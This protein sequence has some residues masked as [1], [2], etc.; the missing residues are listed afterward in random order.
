MLASTLSGKPSP[1]YSRMARTRS[2][3]S[4]RRL[5]PTFILMARKPLARLLS[6]WRRSL[7]SGRSRT[8]PAG[9]DG[10]AGADAASL[11]E[12][13]VGVA[14]ELVERQLQIDAARVARHLGVEAAEVV[15]QGETRA[16]RL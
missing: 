12:F 14:K 4:A 6:V 13:V 16:L 10:R 15:P 8:V 7:S 9:G 5:R 3:S 1:K 2:T 11:S